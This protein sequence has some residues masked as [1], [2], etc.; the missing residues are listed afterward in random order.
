MYRCVLNQDGEVLLHRNMKAGPEPFL[1]ALAPDREDVVVCVECSFTWSWLAALCTR[2]GI[3]FVLGHALS[4]Q[5]IH[6]GNAQNDQLDAH[7]MAGGLRGGRLPQGSVYPA[8]RRA[9]RDLL[10]R[11][12]HL[13]RQ[14]AA[15]L[16]HIQHTNSPYHLPE[17]STKR[18]DTV[19]RDG[20]AERFPEPAVQ[21]RIEVDLARIDHDDRPL[22]DLELDLVQ[23]AT[24]HEAQTFYRLRSIPGVGKSLALV[25]RYEIHAIRRFPRVQAF[26][27]SGRLVKCAKESAGTRDGTSG[28]KI[29]HASL[30]WA[31]SEAAVLF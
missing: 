8:E 6:G 12:V 22:T 13:T 28:K 25:L 11:R 1:K 29:G 24:E 30:Q 18:A 14:R 15:L 19:N 4:M 9:T 7:K 10:R 3:P 2:E 17:I 5:A 23:T 26:V 21:K 20:V 16:A 27:S 31:C